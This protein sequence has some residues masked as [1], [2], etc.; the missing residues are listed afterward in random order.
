[1]LKKSCSLVFCLNKLEK[2]IFSNN[3]INSSIQKDC[4]EKVPGCLEPVSV[5]WD[6]LKSRKAEKKKSCHLA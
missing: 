2:H 6:E 4:M 5:V 1:M 3:L